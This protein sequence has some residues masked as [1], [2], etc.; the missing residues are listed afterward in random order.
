[1]FVKNPYLP[2]K[3]ASLILCD[4]HIENLKNSFKSF[5]HPDILWG[6]NTHPDMTLCPLYNG[7]VLVCKKSYDYYKKLESFGLNVIKG[8]ND[9]SKNYPFDIAFNVVIIDNKLFSNIKYTDKGII[10]YCEDKNIK[11]INVKQG[12]TKCST[13]IVDEKSVITCDRKLND[14]Y[15][16]NGLQSLLVS[17]DE[18]LIKG[19]DHGFIGGCGGKISK[20]VMGFFGDVTKHKDFIKI[21]NFLNERNVTFKILTNGPLFDYGSLTPLCT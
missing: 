16:D 1:M 4:N 6:I 3:E 17:N 11:M 10:K 13:L 5:T 21:N 9:I 8:E 19:F 15:L 14:I 18:I 20:D 7:D 12:Y 2:E